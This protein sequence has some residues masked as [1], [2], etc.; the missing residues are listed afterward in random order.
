V[1]V[2]TFMGAVSAITLRTTNL[3]TANGLEILIPNKD[4]FTKPVTNYTS[5]PGR[6]VDLKVG[7]SYDADLAEVEAVARAAVETVPGRIKEKDIEFFF[8]EFGESSINFQL[9]IWVE[10]RQ[11]IDQVS[12]LHHAIVAVKAAFDLNKIEIP[13][14]IRT[15][16]LVPSVLPPQVRQPAPPQP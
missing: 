9:R 6:R 1:Q 4:M 7:V 12:T 16:D 14:P 8:T 2:D 15:L 10:F 3:Q 5:T 11:Q 13:F